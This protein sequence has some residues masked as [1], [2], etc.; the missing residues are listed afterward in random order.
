MRKY[1]MRGYVRVTQLAEFKQVELC[2]AL[3]EHDI[4]QQDA[5]NREKAKYDKAALELKKAHLEQLDAEQARLSKREA[6]LELLN[7]ELR[8]KLYAESNRVVMQEQSLRNAA[9]LSTKQNQ[10]EAL[11][12]ERRFAELNKHT[13]GLEEFKEKYTSLMQDQMTNYKV[14]LN[15]EYA[16][17]FT[18][19]ELDRTRLQGDRL[20][21][22]EKAKV[23]ENSISA[24]RSK[25]EEIIMLQANIKELTTSNN[26]L[27]Q[28]RNE[29]QQAVKQLESQMLAQQNSTHLE[30]EISSLKR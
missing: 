15:K 1:Y 13:K 28:D 27:R 6:E 20:V 30:F 18:S 10:L 3:I 25:D 19:L 17:K 9:E 2:K 22:A 29:R 12:L 5:L 23:C 14:E 7:G 11:A 24:L 21:L 16:A 4:A 8:Q 26:S